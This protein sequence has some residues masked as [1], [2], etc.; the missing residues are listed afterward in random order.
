MV[1]PEMFLFSF[2]S[3]RR[4]SLRRIGKSI[5]VRAKTGPQA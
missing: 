2:F 4:N 5:L 1:L 3:E